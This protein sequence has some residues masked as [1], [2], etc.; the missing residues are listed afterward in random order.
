MARTKSSSYKKQYTHAQPIK[1]PWEVDFEQSLAKHG[2]T[3]CTA[4]IYPHAIHRGFEA[5]R[6]SEPLVRRYDPFEENEAHRETL[7][8][9][10]CERLKIPFET[11]HYFSPEDLWKEHDRLTQKKEFTWDEEAS[12]EQSE[13]E[14]EEL[15]DAA[16]QVATPSK[17]PKGLVGEEEIEG[18]DLPDEVEVASDLADLFDSDLASQPSSESDELE[19]FTPETSPILETKEK[20]ILDH[21]DVPF[22]LQ[23]DDFDMVMTMDYALIRSTL[24]KL[25]S[26]ATEMEAISTSFHKGGSALAFLG[27]PSLAEETDESSAGSLDG[28]NRTIDIAESGR[29]SVSLT[30]RLKGYESPGWKHDPLAAVIREYHDGKLLLVMVGERYG[31]PDS[32]TNPLETLESFFVEVHQVRTHQDFPDEHGQIATM[33]QDSCTDLVQA[34]AMHDLTS[35]MLA[36]IAHKAQEIAATI[37]SLTSG[38]PLKG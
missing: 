26:S 32:C 4:T 23:G 12:W 35:K 22:T 38:P 17:M 27:R 20:E 36:N 19:P 8:R 31:T 24:D 25:E 7:V 28:L 2:P 34:G 18:D 33:L 10:F 6:E 15:E 11:S 13:S 16:A 14:D 9:S 5:D 37:D 21:V 29:P 1:E 30:S 3:A